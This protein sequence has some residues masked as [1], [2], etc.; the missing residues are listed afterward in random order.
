MALVL[1]LS[2][3]TGIGLKIFWMLPDQLMPMRA[4]M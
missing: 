3:L 1:P 4:A 2:S